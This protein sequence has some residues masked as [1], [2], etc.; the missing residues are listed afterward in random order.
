[1][2]QTIKIKIFDID[3]YYRINEKKFIKHI[4]NIKTLIPL[5]IIFGIGLSLF[6]FGFLTG[7]DIEVMNLKNGQEEVTLRNYG[8]FIGIGCGL[9][10]YSFIK[11][12]DRRKSKKATEILYSIK[13][14]RYKKAN[15]SIEFE[16]SENTI[17]FSSTL[18]NWNTKWEYFDFYEITNSYLKLY[19]NCFNSSLPKIIV[20]INELDSEQL[21]LLNKFLKEKI[22]TTTNN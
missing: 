22:K 5:I 12:L 20:P 9:M 8:L 10:L 17:N 21:N 1:M 14:N 15:E 19:S 18:N 16:L 7:Y 3:R 11:I 2:E 13:R 4:Y 6:I